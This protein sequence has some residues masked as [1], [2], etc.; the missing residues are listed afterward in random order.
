SVFAHRHAGVQ[1]LSDHERLVGPLRESSKVDHSGAEGYRSRIDVGDPKHRNED[2]L[3][4]QQLDY[5]TEYSGSLMIDAQ[6]G[7]HI[8]HAAD[9]LAVRPE[10]S[11]TPHLR[12]EHPGRSHTE[13]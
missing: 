12:H 8:A 6:R 13:Q 11:K 10:D 4:C 2:A 1:Q 9:S 7:G 5:Q 3:S